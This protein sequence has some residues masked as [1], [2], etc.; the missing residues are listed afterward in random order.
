MSEELQSLLAKINEEGVK[1]A[2]AERERI[3]AEAEAE[4]KTIRAKAKA[5]ADAAVKAAADQAAALEARAASAVRQ[6]A[7]DII[8]EL[9]VE[10]QRRVTRAVATAADQALTPA[11]MAE[12]IRSLAVRFAADPNSSVTV[13]SAV[14]DAAALDAALTGALLNSFHGKPQVF[15]DAGIKGGMEVSFRDGQVYFDFTAEAVT[16]LVK[17]YIGPRLGALLDEK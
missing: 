11:F 6:A 13:L 9:Q 12:L 3:L 14:K 1:K 7:R 10:L 2:D 17:A 16:E 4:A 15:G 5:D 8:L